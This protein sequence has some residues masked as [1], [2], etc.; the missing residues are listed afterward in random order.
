MTSEGATKQWSPDQPETTKI[1][2]L[3]STQKK[4]ERK[5]RGRPSIR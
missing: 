2:R 4:K 1:V 3:S 5:E